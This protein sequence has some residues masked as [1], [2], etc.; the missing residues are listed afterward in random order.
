ME[1][2]R[3][4][5]ILA[6]IEPYVGIDPA[7]LEAKAAIGTNVHQSIIDYC[8]CDFYVNDTQRADAYFKSWLMWREHHTDTINQVPRLYCD[9][10]MLTGECDGLMVHSEGNIIVDWKC[11]ANANKKI[12]NLQAHYYWYLLEKNGHKPADKMLWVN[13]RHDKTKVGENVVYVPKMP[14]SYTFEFSE[15]TLSYC[16]LKAQEYHDVHSSAI[17]FD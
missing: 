17:V 6:W 9:D 7:V 15:E 12:W 8:N 4:S 5:Q 3:V 11:S 16:I 10:L 13:L 2:V 14:I 1:H